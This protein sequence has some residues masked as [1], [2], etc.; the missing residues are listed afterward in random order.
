[1]SNKVAGGGSVVFLVLL[2]IGLLAQIPKEV[3][4]GIGVI[5]GFVL[6]LA[7][8]A[9]AFSAYDKSRT[10]AEERA[11][12]ERAAQAAA[13]KREREER[14]RKE[15]QHRIETLGKENAALVESALAAAKQVG[16]SEA[17]RTGWLGDVDFTADIRGIT[18]TFQKAHALR[19][20]A[21]KLSDLDK[22]SDDDRRILSEAK[23]TVASL[24]LTAIERVELIVKC[25]TEARLVDK[26]LRD[27]RKDART[28]EQ[29][30]ELHA[31]LS[32]ML[33]GIEATPDTKPMDS[34]VDAVMARVE[35]YREI[36]SQIQLARDN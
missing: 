2:L 5:A 15:K 32:G 35:A 11:R 3:W 21:N 30:A 28:A 33:Y 29:R 18:D 8:L 34:A 26:S 17:A 19:K 25:A 22:P 9:W 10:A 24:E 31:K 36:K 4:I 20:V 6:V 12:V 14:T 16:A 27:E 13:A 7:F 1:M 23:A